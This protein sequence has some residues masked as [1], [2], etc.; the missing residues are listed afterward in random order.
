M[1][2]SNNVRLIGRWN[3]SKGFNRTDKNHLSSSILFPAESFI[4]HTG[5]FIPFPT[6]FHQVSTLLL[7][8]QRSTRVNS[9]HQ[10]N[11]PDM[12]LKDSML[13]LLR[14]LGIFPLPQN[15]R[16]CLKIVKSICI[17]F[18]LKVF[19]V[20]NSMIVLELA[21]LLNFF[22][23]TP[24]FHFTICRLIDTIFWDAVLYLINKKKIKIII[25]GLNLKEMKNNKSSKDDPKI[26][27]LKNSIVIS[28][29]RSLFDFVIMYYLKTMVEKAT[30]DEINMKFFNWN[31]L[32]SAPD[33][34]L[35]R[36]IMKYDENWEYKPADLEH[37]I[38]RCTTNENLKPNNHWVVHFPEV[39]IFNEKVYVTQAQQNSNYYLPK[40]ENLLYP[41]FNN[42]NNLISIVQNDQLSKIPELPFKNLIDL[43]ILYYDPLKNAFVEPKLLEIF[44]L[45]QPILIISIDIKLKPLNKLPTKQ[46]K[47]EKW[48]EKDWCEKDKQLDLT[49][50]NL[51]IDEWSVNI[52]IIESSVQ[53][54]F[55]A[56]PQSYR[57]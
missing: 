36:N 28:N 49:Q 42:F 24:S 17:L 33:L 6:H 38:R 40:L 11:S 54:T 3:L 52:Y 21:I 16:T 53:L 5:D 32:W 22:I 44:T 20:I 56:H 14:S 50:K 1:T 31:K 35:L 41:R 51:K 19:I 55:R 23:I 43:N 8:T 13:D 25:T 34:S 46:R 39:N 2:W 4:N 37:E 7:W 57:S 15:L 10:T 18:L 27:E 9:R 47:L 48:L 29:H 26:Q 45:K 12:P 30:D